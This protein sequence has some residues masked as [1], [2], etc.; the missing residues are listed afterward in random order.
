MKEF[1]TRN[2]LMFV[3]LIT[4]ILIIMLYF[5]LPIK[6][7]IDCVFLGALVGFLISSFSIYFSQIKKE[8]NEFDYNNVVIYLEET[9]S[10]LP[11]H[12]TLTR[13]I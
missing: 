2:K 5:A 12:R 7:F 4:S 13:K 1:Y 8:L 6:A 9:E 10:N 11:P 3:V